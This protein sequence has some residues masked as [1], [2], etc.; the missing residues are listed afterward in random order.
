MGDEVV[1][2]KISSQLDDKEY[3]GQVFSWKFQVRTIL[4]LEMMQDN[5]LNNLG[6]LHSGY[7]FWCS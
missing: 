5:G 6:M 2:L 4:H 3:L 7:S 1:S